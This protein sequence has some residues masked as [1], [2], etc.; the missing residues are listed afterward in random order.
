[1]KYS[2]DTQMT[3]LYNNINCSNVLVTAMQCL[4]VSAGAKCSNLFFSVYHFLIVILK[5]W[6][7]LNSERLLLISRKVFFLFSGLKQIF[8]AEKCFVNEDITALWVWDVFFT[9]RN[10]M[11]DLNFLDIT[12]EPSRSSAFSH[13][14]QT[15]ECFLYQVFSFKSKNCKSSCELFRI[16]LSQNILCCHET[17]YWLSWTMPM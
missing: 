2:Q 8:V 6:Q 13:N 7:K 4:L 1:M 5:L 10:V 9:H 11:N 12:G 14:N 16:E 15:N 3:A 17:F